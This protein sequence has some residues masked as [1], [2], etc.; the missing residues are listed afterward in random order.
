MPPW[1]LPYKQGEWAG[2]AEGWSARGFRAYRR[3][4]WHLSFSDCQ[5]TLFGVLASAS[6]AA[7]R[8]AAQLGLTPH[9]PSAWIGLIRAAQSVMLLHTAENGVRAAG[10]IPRGLEEAMNSRMPGMCPLSTAFCGSQTTLGRP[11]RREEAQPG[12]GSNL[13]LERDRRSVERHKFCESESL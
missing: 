2:K 5:N 7:D 9:V 4:R 13:Q 8:R 12:G 11:G 6:P 3:P 10:G 1:V